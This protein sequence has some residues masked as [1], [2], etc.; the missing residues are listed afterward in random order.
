M[1]MSWVIRRSTIRAGLGAAI[2]GWLTVGAVVAMAGC[3]NAEVR[4][5][6]STQTDAAT[7]L[8]PTGTVQPTASAAPATA[9]PI[10]TAPASVRPASPQPDASRASWVCS[11]RRSPSQLHRDFL[12]HL[13]SSELPMSS[14]DQL[15]GQLP[16]IEAGLG[17]YCGAEAAT[18]VPALVLAAIHYREANND[19]TRSILSGEPLGSTN[20]DSG[21]VEGTEPLSNAIL[22]AQHLRR[23]GSQVYGVRVDLSMDTGDLAYALAAYNRGGRYCRAKPM[24][25]ML[26]PYVANGLI[27]TLVAMNW[28]DVGSNDTAGP[29]AWGEPESVRGRPDRRLG[30]LTVQRGLGSEI[31]DR[32]YSW[33]TGTAQKACRVA[34]R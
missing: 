16:R 13:A 27:T 11:S 4:A 25:P 15:L 24:H 23:G 29:A 1:K 30:A 19:P 14:R 22:A 26:S 17:T 32:G 8:G 5:E 10:T 31:T 21:S 2:A 6:T 18:G 20:P 34:R 3:G 33:D 28:P 9:T 7:P 12:D